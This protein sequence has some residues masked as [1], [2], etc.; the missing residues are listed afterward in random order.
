MQAR[1]LATAGGTL[2]GFECE[3]GWLE[4]LAEQ[5]IAAE[6]AGAI[7]AGALGTARGTVWLKG[8][9]LPGRA[10]L[11][12]SLRWSV[13]LG[14]PRTRELL[15]LEWLRARLFRCPRPLAAA[16]LLR[17]GLV[18]YQVLALAPLD[19]HTSLEQA[20]EGAAHADRQRW[21]D[22]LA[23]EVARM[24]ALHFVHRDLFLR[25]VAVELAPVPTRGDPR[26]LLLLDAWRSGAALPRR[27]FEYD[28]A[29][30]L[31]DG[32]ALL[33]R[34]EQRGFLARYAEERA[35]QD[36]PLDWAHALPVIDARRREL[37]RRVAGDPRRQRGRVPPPL[38]W[39]WRSL[40]L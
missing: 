10:R 1:S 37:A 30:A 29:C 14:V 12:H 20:L 40:S 32:A 27:G 36:R 13:G 2:R 39:D 16:V 23:R 3:R 38:E 6:R 11:R 28:L 33:E 18:R 35:A 21:L 26:R 9:H 22:E 31:L 7:L 4:L 24:H 19:P 8:D 5:V 15:N 34:D 17:G 25:N